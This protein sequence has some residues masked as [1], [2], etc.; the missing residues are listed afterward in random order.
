MLKASSESPEAALPRS[1]LSHGRTLGKGS[2]VSV[3]IPPCPPC[4]SAHLLVGLHERGPGLHD[5]VA[6][7]ALAQGRCLVQAGLPA[8][9]QGLAVDPIQS[10]GPSCLRRGHQKGQEVWGPGARWGAGGVA[11]RATDVARNSFTGSG[12]IH[13]EGL[14][15]TWVVSRVTGVLPCPAQILTFPPRHQGSQLVLGKREGE[16]REAWQPPPSPGSPRGTAHRGPAGSGPP[17]CCRC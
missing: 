1:P 14:D 15:G 10:S 17:P 7:G 12:R 3:W 5:V 8:G 4:P 9:G 13:T 6:D 2:S 16:V 11:Q